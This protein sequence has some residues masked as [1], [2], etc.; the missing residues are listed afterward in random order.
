MKTPLKN[1]L[2][3]IVFTVTI[4]L[5]SVATT[6]PLPALGQS[7]PTLPDGTGGQIRIL[8]G[9]GAF[10][11]VSDANDVL[12]VS[13]GAALNGTVQLSVLNLAPAANNAVAPLIYTPSWG[14]HSNSWRQI[15]PWVPTGQSQQQ[16]QIS[17]TAPTA[18]GTY[19]IIFSVSWEVGGD[20]VASGTSWAI[21]KDLGYGWVN[22]Y[23]IWNDGND[24]ADFNAAQ[25]SS[26]QSNGWA[27]FNVLN[28]VSPMKYTQRPI[29]ADAITLV[30]SAN[31]SSTTTSTSSGT[32]APAVM[33]AFAVTNDTW[34]ALN[35]DN[36]CF[37]IATLELTWFN[38]RLSQPSLSRLRD[39]YMNCDAT[40]RRNLT[41]TA[42]VRTLAADLFSA[43]ILQALGSDCSILQSALKA[44]HPAMIVMQSVPPLAHAVVAIGY[45]ETSSSV[46]FYTAD[47]NFPDQEQTMTYDKK[48][49]TWDY[50]W[51]DSGYWSKVYPNTKCPNW[52]PF[53]V[54]YVTLNGLLGSAIFATDLTG[55]QNGVINALLPNPVVQSVSPSQTSVEVKQTFPVTVTVKNTGPSSGSFDIQLVDTAWAAILG[56]GWTVAS[57]VQQNQNFSGYQAQTFTFN[58]TATTEG[59]HSFN[60]QARMSGHVLWDGSS[61]QS[62]NVVASPSSQSPSA[63][64]TTTPGEPTAPLPPTPPSGPKFP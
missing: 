19:H 60:G 54:G 13:P 58:V 63:S 37:G 36:T 42:E 64:Q 20:H 15:N 30:V 40:M 21:G 27:Y 22:N 18:P 9:T 7:I 4:S 50:Y 34:G 55:F 53:N 47:S 28:S 59:T 61:L 23:D 29:P 14:D 25:L 24:L 62:A 49:Q 8:S 26:A 6:F 48:A 39:V 35:T 17:L 1:F 12:N 51:N 45:E 2:I 57:P 46:I 31:G 3:S 38:M 16:A 56:G 5:V 11:S 41:D 33:T 52:S 10:A 43:K 32:S 44:G